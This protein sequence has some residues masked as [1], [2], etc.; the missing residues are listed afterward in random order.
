[1]EWSFGGFLFGKS[2]LNFNACQ[3]CGLK[4]LLYHFQPIFMTVFQSLGSR[5]VYFW[6]F[7]EAKFGSP[8]D[9][10]AAAGVLV[11]KLFFC[12]ACQK[13]SEFSIILENR[14]LAILRWVRNWFC[15]SQITTGFYFHP[16]LR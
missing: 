3:L 10:F 16:H 5:H 8:Y 11:R 14:S 12:R 13:E 1:M 2:G 9:H 6:D 7:G 15:H 4:K